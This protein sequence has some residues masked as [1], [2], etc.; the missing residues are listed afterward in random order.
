MVFH[1]EKKNSSLGFCDV[2]LILQLLRFSDRSIVQY[3]VLSAVHAFLGVATDTYKMFTL[4]L[5]CTNIALGKRIH[6]S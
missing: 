1:L 6:S 4:T 3:S 2:R 5:P